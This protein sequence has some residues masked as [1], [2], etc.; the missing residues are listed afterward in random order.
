MD[1]YERV[2]QQAVLLELGDGVVEVKAVENVADVGRDAVQ[3]GARVGR[4]TLR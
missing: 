2:E 1:R 4:I 3:G